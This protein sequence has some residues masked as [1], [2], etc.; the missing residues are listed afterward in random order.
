MTDVKYPSND[1]NS[2]ENFTSFLLII[3]ATISSVVF[4]SC[5]LRSRGAVHIGPLPQEAHVPTLKDKLLVHVLNYLVKRFS[6][7]SKHRFK[8][9]KLEGTTLENQAWNERISSLCDG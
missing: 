7:I 1:V 5:S 9:S 6:D 4:S 2:N 3:L 8:S